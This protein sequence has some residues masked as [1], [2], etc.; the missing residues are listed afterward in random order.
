MSS[1]IQI[2]VTPEFD[3]DAAAGYWS[4][5]VLDDDDPVAIGKRG[6]R[7]SAIKA[8]VDAGKAYEKWLAEDHEDLDVA[9]DAVSVTQFSDPH[10]DR[11][12]IL[13]EVRS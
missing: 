2:V 5:A 8:A 11:R 1:T 4:Y 9:L 10:V 13:V 3:P 6:D 7:A 12:N